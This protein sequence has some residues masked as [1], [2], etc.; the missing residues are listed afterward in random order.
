MR[1]F[2][3]KKIKILQYLFLQACHLIRMT[4]SSVKMHKIVFAS[5]EV[6]S[7]KFPRFLHFFLE[8]ILKNKRFSFLQEISVTYNDDTLMPLFYSFLAATD[9]IK[10]FFHFFP[11]FLKNYSPGG[12]YA[13]SWRKLEKIYNKYGC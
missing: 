8:K 1:K 6:H 11:S 3:N 10:K 9:W 12:F 7:L 4:F 13:Y 5:G 2:K